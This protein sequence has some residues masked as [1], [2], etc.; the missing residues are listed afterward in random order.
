MRE[1]RVKYPTAALA[2]IEFEGDVWG[3]IDWGTGR[4]KRFV[5]PRDL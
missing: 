4:V 2:E 1:M 3:E 5:R